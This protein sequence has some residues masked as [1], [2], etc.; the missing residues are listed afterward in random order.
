MTYNDNLIT[1]LILFFILTGASPKNKDPYYGGIEPEKYVTGR[2]DPA[3]SDLFME[4]KAAGIETDGRRHFLRTDTVSALKKLLTA[5]KKDHPN[6]RIY[7]RSA[8]RGYKKQKQIWERKWNGL[9]KTKPKL[10][11][12]DKGLD[13]LKYSAMP[14][15]SRHHWGTDFDINSFNNAYFK[16]GTGKII[17]DWMTEN[18]AG[19]GFCQ[20]YTQGRD[21]GYEEEKWHW[22]YH[23]AAKHFYD[24]WIEF[25]Q[26]NGTF[27]VSEESFA[28]AGGLL[29]LAQIYVTSVNP[30]CRGTETSN[31]GL[32]NPEGRK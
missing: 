11:D 28:G 29:D 6:I 31:A 20:P 2:F 7:I 30:A 14:G 18:A 8:T 10:S 27:M 3:A 5:F 4:L 1:L 25:H 24:A 15:T 22:S 16:T 21:A 32:K 19:F 17:Y 12:R 23:P 9:T 26:K 13:I